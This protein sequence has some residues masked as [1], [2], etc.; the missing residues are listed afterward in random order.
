[1][2]L[3]LIVITQMA[4]LDG[5]S[6]EYKHNK[7]LYRSTKLVFVRCTESECLLLA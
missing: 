2:F 1:M 3:I 6:G 7:L 4:Q 5:E